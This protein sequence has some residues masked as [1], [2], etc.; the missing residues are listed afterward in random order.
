MQ[1]FEEGSRLRLAEPEPDEGMALPATL[2]VR[3]SRHAE[4]LKRRSSLTLCSPSAL[5]EISTPDLD[6]ESEGQDYEPANG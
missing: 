6:D 2:R 1:R 3:G 4:R 5:A